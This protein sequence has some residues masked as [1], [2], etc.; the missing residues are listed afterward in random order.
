MF[1][2]RSVGKEI[3]YLPGEKPEAGE[4]PEEALIREIKEEAGVV[5]RSESV[6]LKQH[7]TIE[8]HG[9]H[10]TE[11]KIR[12]YFAEYDGI[13]SPMTEIEEVGWFD[14]SE[15]VLVPPAGKL[16]LTWLKEEDLVD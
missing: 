15:Q 13:I 16:I 7:F 14:S 6:E 3:F 9:R 4:T 11:V 5:L 12:A 8:A 2:L 1:F 10:D